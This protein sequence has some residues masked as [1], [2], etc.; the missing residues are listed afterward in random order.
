MQAAVAVIALWGAK[1]SF[2]EALEIVE[3]SKELPA[4]EKGY[5]RML[6]QNAM[7]VLR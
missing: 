6:V 1:T 7:K 5:I 2:D 3:N 4:E